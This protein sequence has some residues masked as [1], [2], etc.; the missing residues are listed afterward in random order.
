MSLETF[1]AGW[2]LWVTAM[3]PPTNSQPVFLM[4]TDKNIREGLPLFKGNPCQEIAV[5]NG[6]DPGVLTF[7]LFSHIIETRLLFG[8]KNRN[9]VNKND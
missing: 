8:S 3:S 2:D 1:L 5:S 4:M 7:V 9:E 6:V